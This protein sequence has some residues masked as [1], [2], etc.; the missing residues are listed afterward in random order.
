V[1]TA[2]DQDRGAGVHSLAWDGR[3]AGGESAAP[4]VYTMRMEFEGRSFS[5]AFIRLR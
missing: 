1:V 5:R 3:A 2:L 4:G